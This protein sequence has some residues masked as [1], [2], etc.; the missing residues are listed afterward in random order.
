MS[1]PRGL[2]LLC[3]LAFV[4]A[5]CEYIAGTNKDRIVS[6]AGS[7]TGGAGAGGTPA[8]DGGGGTGGSTG[9][10][11]GGV[12]TGGSA[13]LDASYDVPVDLPATLGE[14]GVRDLAGS[15][16]IGPMGG[17]TGGATSAG[18]KGGRDDAA[19][20][21][22]GAGGIHG[23]GGSVTNDAAA[24]GK[25]AGGIT[26]SGGS[27]PSTGGQGGLCQEPPSACNGDLSNVGT[28]DLEIK[29]TINTST[30]VR[31]ALLNQRSVCSHSIFWDVELVDGTI[32]VELDDNDQHYTL[33]R[34]TKLVNDGK[35]HR[36]VTRR[37]AGRL[38]TYIDCVLDAT[39]AAA[40]DLTG[41]LRPL[42]TTLASCPN[43]PPPLAGTLNEVCVSS[44]SVDAGAG[45]AGGADAAT[46]DTPSGNCQG[47]RVFDDFSGSAL[48]TSKWSTNTSVP[49]GSASVVQTGGHVEFTNRGFLDT[50]REF[51]PAAGGVRVTGK[52]TY[53]AA[54]I[55]DSLQVVTRTD[56]VPQGTSGEVQ[57]GVQC[58]A[59]AA[60]S[61]VG[62]AGWGT[63]VT[64]ATSSG[65]LNIALGDT[66]VFEMT[67]DGAR[68]TCAFVNLTSGLRGT[69][70]ATSTLSSATNR[71]AFHNRELEDGTN[72]SSADDITIE[73]GFVNRPTHH[74]MFEEAGGTATYDLSG[75]IN[76]VLATGATRSAAKFGP[77]VSFAGTTDGYVNLGATASALGTSDFTMAFWF[78]VPKRTHLM[79]LLGNRV[80]GDHG[81]FVQI[82]MNADGT[83]SLE[84][85]EDVTGTNYQSIGS[86]TAYDDNQWHNLAVRRR[87]LA[88][89]MFVD[90]V[91]V[92]SGTRA[93]GAPADLSNGSPLRL[94]NSAIASTYDLMTTGTFDDVRIY[95]AALDECAIAVIGAQP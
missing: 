28:G 2:T 44:G 65:A 85:D 47:V 41:T 40:T 24:G 93:S 79:D 61:A 26:A 90:G 74:Y 75:T 9:A 82:R 70:S 78:K 39:C 22:G 55:G 84:I 57:T 46:P 68:V 88:L 34:G 4:P 73:A 43:P 8:I 60:T 59:S 15:G 81:N 7:G 21:G 58:F 45:G 35:P 14:V 30:T 72:R 3:L 1:A 10:E 33:C 56:G 63:T 67:D 17:A 62:V 5:G 18:G 52:W 76:G 19:A 66:L 50:V 80:N 36:V 83:V 25:G 12:A 42:Q 13:G 29:F 23:T 11:V 87:G 16:G 71:I 31:S 91:L 48:D 89:A 86:S 38:S 37:V 20:G 53:E 77:G 95:N 32:Q 92:T 27:G 69:A 49:Q 6:P 64:N 51:V 54:P 94:G